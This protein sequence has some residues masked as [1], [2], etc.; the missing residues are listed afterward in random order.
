M[1]VENV[2]VNGVGIS[3]PTELCEVFRSYF[4]STFR[5]DEGNDPRL[6]YSAL[7]RM[8]HFTISAE[9]AHRQLINLNPSKSDGAGEIHAKILT[10]LACYLATSLVK[11][12]NNSLE[13]GSIP[14]EWKLS[15]ICPICKK[16]SK[17]NVANYR[18]IC[19]TSVVCKILER[20]KNSQVLKKLPF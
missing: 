13:P 7:S 3:E 18:P 10:S 6:N 14:V 20:S 17:N 16:G 8:Q 5:N 11:L 19:L 4:S 9:N 15:I 2:F 12:F 1:D